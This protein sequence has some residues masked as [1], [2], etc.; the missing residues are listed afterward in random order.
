MDTDVE[1]RLFTGF[2]HRF[3]HFSFGFFDG[4]F[5][6][7]RMNPAVFNQ[8]FQG[9]TRDFPPYGMETGQR[10]RFRSIIND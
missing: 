4:F 9:N 3:I 6:T 7:S 8:V 2:T 1:C 10:H 5:N